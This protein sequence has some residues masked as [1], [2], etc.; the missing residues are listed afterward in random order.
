MSKAGRKG[1]HYC[2]GGEEFAEPLEESSGSEVVATPA[3][4]VEPGEDTLEES[5]DVNGGVEEAGAPSLGEEEE[6]KVILP[7]TEPP[8]S[9]RGETVEAAM[10]AQSVEAQEQSERDSNRL[11]ERRTVGGDVLFDGTSAV[12][13]G[14]DNLRWMSYS[15][16]RKL[17]LFQP[18]YRLRE[19]KQ[20]TLFWSKVE[21]EYVPRVLV[22]YEEPNVFLVLRRPAGQEE[23]ARLV[24][25]VEKGDEANYWVAESVIDPETCKLKLSNLTTP[26]SLVAIEEPDDRAR[27]VFEIISP[28]E[29]VRVSAVRPRDEAKKGERSFVDSGSFLETTSVEMSVTKAIC[30]AHEEREVANDLAW[31]HQ[32]TSSSCLDQ[33]HLNCWLTLYPYRL[34]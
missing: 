30:D 13:M 10:A 19:V 29:S 32:G 6:E 20:K 5:A 9:A 21:K 11:D 23:L 2:G 8:D 22:I 34:Q 31:K 28:A 27:S 1:S 7:D 16:A 15:G 24:G 25:V 17:R 14:W 33:F 4:E 18:V 26:T 3:A 12:Y